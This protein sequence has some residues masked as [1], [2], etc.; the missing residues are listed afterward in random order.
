[1]FAAF[2]VS[3]VL[4]FI[5]ILYGNR[6]LHTFQFLYFGWRQTAAEIASL[7]VHHDQTSMGILVISV[8]LLHSKLLQFL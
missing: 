3:I 7:L 8:N 4:C 1:M 6:N 2:G 5:K